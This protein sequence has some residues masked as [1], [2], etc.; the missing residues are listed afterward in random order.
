MSDLK[1]YG[2]VYEVDFDNN[3]LS[4][5]VHPDLLKN[6]NNIDGLV[7]LSSVKSLLEE[8]NEDN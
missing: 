5:H 2:K 8:Y 7:K 4:L 6:I 3:I 1:Y